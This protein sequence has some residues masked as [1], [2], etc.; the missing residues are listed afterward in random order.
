MHF[1][2]GFVDASHVSEGHADGFLG[3][4]SVLGFSEAAQHPAW[5]TTRTTHAPDKEEPDGR[6]QDDQWQHAGEQAHPNAGAC[7]IGVVDVSFVQLLDVNAGLA[8]L[9]E[10][11]VGAPVWRFAQPTGSRADVG[12]QPVVF[13][14]DWAFQ[15]TR[16]DGSRGQ[17]IW[18]DGLA[19]G[20][21]L[22]QPAVVEHLPQLVDLDALGGEDG[23]HLGGLAFQGLAIA[24][25]NGVFLVSQPT[26]FVSVCHLSV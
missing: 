20:I 14:R 25:K 10:D 8:D 23:G 22:H 5:S 15:A 17:E 18:H 12:D 21:S 2:F 4:Q 7:F 16:L 19:Q 11:S 9:K 1:V 13:H 24:T 26:Q 6:D 3:R